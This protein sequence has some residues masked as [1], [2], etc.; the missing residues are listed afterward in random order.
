MAAKKVLLFLVLL[1][2]TAFIFKDRLQT[3]S[4]PPKIK[5]GPS[6]DNS[7]IF[8]GI[9]YEATNPDIFDVSILTKELFSPTRLKI[10]PDGNHL[11]ISQITGEVLALDRSQAGWSK[12]PYL[13]TKVE[14]KFP[15]FPP[16]EAGLVGMIFSEQFKENGKLFLLYTFKDK[17]GKIQN[18]ISTSSLREVDGK[19]KG[20]PPN[21]IFQANVAGN[22]SH[23]ITD[24]ISV[25][26]NGEPHLLFLI[27]EGFDAKRAQDPS[28][29]AGKLILMNED[30]SKRKIA[31]LGI[32]NGYVLAKNPFDKEGRIL[33]SDTGPDKYD[34]L[35]YT[36]PLKIGQLNFGWNGDQEKL[37]RPI[38]D[39][40]FPKVS[41]MVIYRLAETR[42][43]VGLA[44]QK[45][46]DVLATLF[47]KT[48]SKEN[49]PGKEILLG[50]LTNLSGQP[51]ISFQT[52]LKRTSGANGKL[53]N[54]IGMEIDQKTGDFFFAD[55]LEGRIYQ[56]K[57]KGGD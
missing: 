32:R 52:I 29:E 46:G 25:D 54:P 31:A 11:L 48:G 41:D 43:F 13:V 12:E 21:Q 28:V 27:G 35:I 3:F 16:D 15:G 49:S 53:G 24:G 47:G 38:P 50:K 39:P 51:H 8:S 2:I 6:V 23:Q 44:F 57:K 5:K 56:V 14:T 17:D 10:T 33:I 26:I 18:R 55:I 22:P 42:T 30:G 37:T 19:L 34:R 40:N 4:N 45:D 20:S 7:E 9:S 36:D 1:I